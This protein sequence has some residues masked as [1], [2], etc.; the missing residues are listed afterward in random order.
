M[1][2]DNERDGG[3]VKNRTLAEVLHEATHRVPG[4]HEHR[5]YSTGHQGTTGHG[6]PLPHRAPQGHG[7]GSHQGSAPAHRRPPR[8][9]VGWQ[10]WIGGLLS[11]KTD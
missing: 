5:D 9:L 2:F 3:H 7:A 1:P 4:M 11:R 10:N 6:R 8:A